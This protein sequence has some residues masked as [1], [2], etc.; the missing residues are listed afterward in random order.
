MSSAPLPQDDGEDDYGIVITAAGTTLTRYCDP[1]LGGC[2]KDLPIGDF[3]TSGNPRG[4]PVRWRRNICAECDNKRYRDPSLRRRL[5]QRAR[6]RAAARLQEEHKDR[7][8]R[9]YFEELE[10][11]R[12]EAD[13]L[14]RL[15]KGPTVPREPIKLRP[16]R[17][18]P[19]QSLVSRVDTATCRTCHTIHDRKHACPNCGY[20]E[21][22]L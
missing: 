17:K 20:R 13:D 5:D 19:G 16:G 8:R 22:V 9:L 21:E 3:Y 12:E 4:A 1:A 7:Y 18:R 11:A 10:K 15:V 6:H 14:A 2:G